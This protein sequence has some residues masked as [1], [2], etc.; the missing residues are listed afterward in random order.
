ME[1]MTE[2]SNRLPTPTPP[3]HIRYYT[4]N[5]SKLIDGAITAFQIQL[6]EGANRSITN[7]HTLLSRY[8][9]ATGYSIYGVTK[10]E[11]ALVCT[12]RGYNPWE[13]ENRNTPCYYSLDSAETIISPTNIVMSHPKRYAAWGQF[14]HI[15]TGSGHITFYQMEGTNHTVY[16]LKMHNGLWYSNTPTRLQQQSTHTSKQMHRLPA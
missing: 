12:R 4:K 1:L 9:P 6:D 10:D 2:L 15:P 16:T 3:F 11:V 13:A 14:E 7:N 5:Q 8:Q